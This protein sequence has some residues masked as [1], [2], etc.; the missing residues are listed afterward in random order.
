MAEAKVLPDHW[1][2]H[3]KSGDIYFKNKNHVIKKLKKHY[4]VLYSTSSNGVARLEVFDGRKSFDSGSTY[5]LLIPGSEVVSVKENHKPTSNS[6]EEQFGFI[7]STK[8]TQHQFYALN[9]DDRLDWIQKF[10]NTLFSPS[11]SQPQRTTVIFENDVYEPADNFLKEFLVTAGAIVR[12]KFGVDGEVRLHV[13]SGIITLISLEGNRIGRWAVEH[14]RRFGYT[15]TDFH[16]EAGRK[17][18]HGEGC[19]TFLTTQGK[20]IH[21]L[22]N[23]QKTFVKEKAGKQPSSP[24]LKVATTAEEFEIPLTTGGHVYEEVSINN[25]TNT[26]SPPAKPARAHQAR[27]R[28]PTVGKLVEE[29]PTLNSL[30]KVKSQSTKATVQ[31]QP[32]SPGHSATPSQAVYCETV[33]YKDA[34]KTYGRETEP[35][36]ENLIAS[37]DYDKLQYFN[38]M[39]E[40]AADVTPSRTASGS[41]TPDQD[42]REQKNTVVND[43]TQSEPIYAEVYKP[44]KKGNKREKPS[45]NG[46]VVIPAPA[47]KDEVTSKPIEQ[48]YATVCKQNKS[49]KQ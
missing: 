19:F 34:W 23:K 2:G 18:D 41:K 17:S 44:K 5:S 13:E 32:D 21:G 28:L 11:S 30:P 31:R 7:I 6:S 47:E 33:E 20:Q 27:G 9:K 38:Q 24:G 26:R 3:V 4:A 1:L 10:G 16:L 39:S 45:D 29:G 22:V 35:T 49:K 8:E 37:G 15:D 48:I 42:K 14:L 46:I 43:V 36:Y 40:R 12:Q 25:T